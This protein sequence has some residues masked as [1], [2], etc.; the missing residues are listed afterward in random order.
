VKNRL[1]YILAILA[2]L[3]F[4]KVHATHIFGGELLYRHLG[5][6]S[7]RVSL[8]LYGDCSGSSFKYLDSAAPSIIVYRGT[9][10]YDSIE[11]G[12]DGTGLEVSPVC[13]DMFD[14]TA[15][16]V[17]GS[18]LPGVTR[19]IYSG[20]ITLPPFNNWRFAFEGFMGNSFA[21]RSNAITNLTKQSSLMYLEA[22]LNNSA[23]PNSSPH[24]TSIPT[25][26][27]CI[28]IAQ[29][30]NQGASDPDIDSL[31]F[32]L[33]AALEK[34]APVL[35]NMPYYEKAPL[36]TSDFKYDTLSGQ[37]SFT[38]N[39]AQNSVVVNKVTE[40]KNGIL[41][42]Y[43]MREMTF[44]ILPN[45]NNAPPRGSFDGIPIIGGIAP[46]HNTVN[47][48][49][50]E[51]LLEFTIP[52]T[53]ANNDIITAIISNVPAGATATVIHNNSTGPLLN[54]TW[55]TVSAAPGIYNFYVN[56]K[57]NGCPLSSNQTIAYTIR[58]LKRFEMH[59]SIINPTRCLYKQHTRLIVDYGAFPRVLT[60]RQGNNVIAVFIDSSKGYIDSLFPVGDYIVDIRSPFLLCTAVDSF[61]VIDG[62]T[63]PFSPVITTPLHYC[64]NDPVKP[65]E[66]APG[67][68]GKLLWYNIE[69]KLMNGPPEISSAIAGEYT[70]YV[71]ELYDVCESKKEPL[72]LFVHPHPQ[73]Q[74]LNKPER[75]CLGDRVYLQA[76][77]GAEYTWLPI[78]KMYRE[79]IEG[80]TNVYIKAENTTYTMIATSEYG[81]KDTT[82]ISFSD[83]ENCCT[84]S[85]PNAFTPNGDG[86]N[87]G[88]RITL[89]GNEER[90]DLSIYNR[91]GQRVFHSEDPKRYW[92][93]TFNG[94][95]C[96]P[97][98]YYYSIN[99]KC[100]TGHVEQKGGDVILIR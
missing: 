41:V 32:S 29:E 27:Y 93:G 62:G 70:W 73:A 83:V 50:N 76:A 28:N 45:C 30:Y 35:Y 55:N 54:F 26:F 7:Y 59:D 53:D 43:S 89:Y 36:A 72:N 42:G 97:G 48:C 16:K 13:P 99:A 14:S 46:S 84:F 34:G 77:G 61:K 68:Y 38:A 88:F 25:P 90:Y 85:C 15:C 1:L 79:R 98:T 12:I 40:Y 92:D 18:T 47:V 49:V 17:P 67:R 80:D 4:G 19:Y 23:G 11:I 74:I 33:V 52:F 66:V 100:L 96:D 65:I 9:Q 57:D 58:I 20:N 60:V 71:S 64:V 39:K 31:G 5:G 81:C 51:P 8:T 63:Y 44:I 91:W 2:L 69:G 95:L 86:K 3:S 24:Y 21:G 6:N 56:L 10:F 78:D 75:V 37:L 94:R 82:S 22:M 87:D